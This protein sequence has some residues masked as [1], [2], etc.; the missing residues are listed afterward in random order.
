MVRRGL[1]L[2]LLTISVVVSCLAIAAPAEAAYC[3][4][5]SGKEVCVLK[6]KRSAKFY[7]EY[8]AKLRIDGQKVTRFYN[9]RD[10]YYT[11]PDRLPRDFAKDDPLG[12][13][14]CFLYEKYLQDTGSTPLSLK[15]GE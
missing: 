13:S 15:A 10:R 6:L 12:K 14:V 4:S 2:L 3:K 7:W 9:C 1:C 5:I 11:Q 8:R